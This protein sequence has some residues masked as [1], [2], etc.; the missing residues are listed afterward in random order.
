MRQRGVALL[1]CRESKEWK[2]STIV[3][4]IIIYSLSFKLQIINC[5]FFTKFLD[6]VHLDI[7]HV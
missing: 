5:F 4:I 6:V 1:I 7:C 2:N 3:V